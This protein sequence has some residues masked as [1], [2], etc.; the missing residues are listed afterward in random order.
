MGQVYVCPPCH[1][2]GCGWFCPCNCHCGRPP[3]CDEGF[4]RQPMCPDGCG[5]PAHECRCWR[6]SHLRCCDRCNDGNAS[7]S[8]TP[9]SC[10]GGRPPVC[11]DA[12]YECETFW[13]LL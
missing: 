6:P 5:S 12:G 2:R 13:S 11:T 8:C 4:G 9:H 7:S 10:D 3:M 1:N